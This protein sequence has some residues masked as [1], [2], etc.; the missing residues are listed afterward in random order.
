LRDHIP[1][2]PLHAFQIGDLRPH[3]VKM[4]GGDGARLGAGPVALVDALGLPKL[5]TLFL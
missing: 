4:R 2:Q 3:V 1:E 5:A